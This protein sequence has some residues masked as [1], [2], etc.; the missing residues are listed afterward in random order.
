VIKF[1]KPQLRAK[2]QSKKA[3]MKQLEANEE[4]LELKAYRAKAERMADRQRAEGKLAE[5]EIQ[6]QLDD[7]I[8]LFKKV[9]SQQRATE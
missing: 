9:R 4:K 8:K 5:A 7:K 3:L 6:K 1:F 2:A